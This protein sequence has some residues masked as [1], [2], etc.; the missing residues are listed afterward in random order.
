MAVVDGIEGAGI[1][2]DTGHKLVYPAAGGPASRGVSPNTANLIPGRPVGGPGRLLS[3]PIMFRPAAGN[4][5]NPAPHETIFCPG[6]DIRKRALCIKWL[7]KRQAAK[8]QDR[9][10]HD[11][12]N[13]RH[14][15]CCV[16]CCSPYDSAR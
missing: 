16:C 3:T 7:T 11:Q 5:T 14:R 10:R 2:R 15:Y 4:E 13:F 6:E 1:K 12:G 9:D 8:A